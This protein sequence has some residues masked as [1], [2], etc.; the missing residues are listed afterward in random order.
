MAETLAAADLVAVDPPEV[1]LPE[2]VR[3]ESV[4]PES[5]PPEPELPDSVLLES[6][7]AESEL[8]DSE[9]ADSELPDSDLP[10][11]ALPE[12]EL[13]EPDGVPPEPPSL[14]SPETTEPPPWPPV[15]VLVPLPAGGAGATVGTLVGALV[16]VV[17]LPVAGAD[18]DPEPVG[19]VVDSTGWLVVVLG[20][21]VLAGVDAGFG[22]TFVDSIRGAEVRLAG[23]V[24][25][26][27]A[28]DTNNDFDD[29]L[30]RGDGS[31]LGRAGVRLSLSSV[32]KPGSGSTAL[33]LTGP[34][35]R[36]TLIRPP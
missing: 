33:E 35:A 19:A 7:P 1:E 36:L 25:R 6:V 29:W 2:A 32:S 30:G 5:V 20:F 28:S 21:G 15:L 10:E 22:A 16:G 34:P 9:L 14:S 27:S 31:G 24:R 18:G 12:T 11:T 17:V 3:P 13:L 8:P 4:L 26:G 23:V